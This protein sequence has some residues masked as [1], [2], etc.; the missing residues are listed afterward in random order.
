[1]DRY[2][3]ALKLEQMLYF[4]ENGIKYKEIEGFDGKYLI[5]STGEVWSNWA[6]GYKNTFD[7]GTGYEVVQLYNTHT[8]RTENRAVHRLVAE[9]FIPKPDYWTPGMALDVGH[10]DDNPKN[11]RLENLFWCSRAENLDTDSFREKAKHRIRG[12]VRCVETGDTF[13]SIAEAGRWLGKHKYG[14]NLCLLGKQ[15]TC[16][17][18]HWERVASEPEAAA[19]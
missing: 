7:K 11:N 2:E 15:K 8:H 12:Q 19:N 5:L 9:A 14:I 18:Y 6:N 17:G 10:R 3:N 16:G 1:M 13:K 4:A